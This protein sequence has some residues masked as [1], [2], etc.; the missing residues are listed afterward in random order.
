MFIFSY[1]LILGS[2]QLNGQVVNIL[3]SAAVQ[4]VKFEKKKKLPS[5]M[6]HSRLRSRLGDTGAIKW[7]LFV[8]LNHISSLEQSGGSL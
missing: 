5:F 8:L 4:M 6:W 2:I 1:F 3:L 7:L